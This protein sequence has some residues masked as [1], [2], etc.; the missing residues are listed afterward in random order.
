MCDFPR[1]ESISGREYLSDIPRSL[2]SAS[3]P[4]WDSA[5]REPFPSR[6]GLPLWLAA[7]S[8]PGGAR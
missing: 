8:R 4:Y 7:L 3:R 2:Y 5:G 1:L 6:T